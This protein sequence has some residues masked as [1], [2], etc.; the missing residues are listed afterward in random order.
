MR[1]R[2][3]KSLILIRKDTDRKRVGEMKEILRG[4]NGNFRSLFVRQSLHTE[5][6]KVARMLKPVERR[7]IAQHTGGNRFE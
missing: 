2:R 5:N 4:G 6:D 3:S 1:A 7:D